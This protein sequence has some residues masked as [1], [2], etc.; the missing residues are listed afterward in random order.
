MKLN[1]KVYILDYNKRKYDSKRTIIK[2]A[3]IQEVE[4]VRE[5]NQSFFISYYGQE[6]RYSKK[7]SSLKGE[8]YGIQPYVFEKR[9]DALNYLQPSKK[10]EVKENEIKNYTL[11]KCKNGKEIKLE[12][13]YLDD[14]FCEEALEWA[15]ENNIIPM[16]NT[17]FTAVGIENYI[18]E[19]GI[20][21]VYES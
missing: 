8:L 7:D 5:T 21:P 20:E 18:R 13:R 9:E 6:Y 10:E 1:Q 11:I 12:H 4:V 2:E 17:Y 16:R 3:H 19:T 14:E 15:E